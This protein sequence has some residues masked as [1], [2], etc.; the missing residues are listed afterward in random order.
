[1]IRYKFTKK[2]S[3]QVWRDLSA[4]TAE[5]VIESILLVLQAYQPQRS[6]TRSYQPLGPEVRAYQSLGPEGTGLSVTET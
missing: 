4:S 5:F 3:E 1:M 2:S 6:G